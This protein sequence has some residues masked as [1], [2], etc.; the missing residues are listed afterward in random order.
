MRSTRWNTY[1]YVYLQLEYKG[2][3]WYYVFCNPGTVRTEWMGVFMKLK[4]ITVFVIVALSVS[5][6]EIHQQRSSADVRNGVSNNRT[7]LAAEITEI[8]DPVDVSLSSSAEPPVQRSAYPIA[9]AVPSVFLAG[10]WLFCL[11]RA[12]QALLIFLAM[13]RSQP[14]I[15]GTRLVFGRGMMLVLILCV[16]QAQTTQA[17]DRYFYYSVSTDGNLYSVGDTVHWTTNAGISGSDVTGIGAFDA[18]L[19]ESRGETMSGPMTEDFFVYHHGFITNCIP[20]DYYSHGQIT[21]VFHRGNKFSSGGTGGAGSVSLGAGQFEKK[22]E[23]LVVSFAKA[24]I[25]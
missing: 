7:E 8:A 23:F 6:P 21:S 4:A 3:F 25:Q 19:Y 18:V 16:C 10:F 15:M 13:N 24:R 5:N 1:K 2:L 17:N 22:K 11:L 14:W 12:A 20:E 9:L